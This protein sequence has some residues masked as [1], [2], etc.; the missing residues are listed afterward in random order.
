MNVIK[1]TVTFDRIKD[2]IQKI[3]EQILRNIQKK[4]SI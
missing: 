1:Y 3:Q 2:T 4:P